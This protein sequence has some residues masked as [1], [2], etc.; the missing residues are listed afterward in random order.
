[1]NEPFEEWPSEFEG[2][3]PVETIVSPDGKQRAHFC[4]RRDGKVQFFS[5]EIKDYGDVYYDCLVWTCNGR[6]GLYRDLESARKDAA[7]EI[8]WLR[9]SN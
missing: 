6:S 8:P 5:Q 7:V 2:I 9:K 3:S 1:M 4:V